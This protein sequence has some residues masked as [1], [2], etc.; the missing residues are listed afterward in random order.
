MAI[1]FPVNPRL[2]YKLNDRPKTGV[3][4]NIDVNIYRVSSTGGTNQK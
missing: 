4:L 1:I 3:E 2:E